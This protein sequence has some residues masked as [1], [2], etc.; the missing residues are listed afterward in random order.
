MEGCGAT[1]SVSPL[2]LGEGPGGEGGQRKGHKSP[3][4]YSGGANDSRFALAP[5]SIPLPFPSP[6]G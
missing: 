6:K 5:S 1:L 4:R 2:P 3:Q